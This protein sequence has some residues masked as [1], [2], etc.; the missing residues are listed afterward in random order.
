MTESNMHGP[1][2]VPHEAFYFI[3]TIVG[4]LGILIAAW[5]VSML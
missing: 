3:Y 2:P 5:I 4:V 1:E